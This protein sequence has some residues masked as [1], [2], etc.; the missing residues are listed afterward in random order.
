[1]ADEMEA[2]RATGSRRVGDLERVAHQVVDAAGGEIARGIRARAGRVAALI[3]RDGAL[4]R[5]CER[6]HLRAPGVSR[7]REAVQ[8]QHDGA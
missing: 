8:Q 7:L 2:P 3:R 5:R 6:R 1:V 4:A